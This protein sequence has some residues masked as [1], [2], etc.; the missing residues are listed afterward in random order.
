MYKSLIILALAAAA[1]AYAFDAADFYNTI[2]SSCHGPEGGGDGA[3]GASL[4]VKPANFQDPEFW[5]GR[6]D[7]R[8][9]KAIK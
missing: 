2:C 6:D 7:A 4:P 3:A 5:S 9:K 8:V 1:P